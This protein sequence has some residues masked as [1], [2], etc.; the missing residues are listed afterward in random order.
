MR[1]HGLRGR[2]GCR[3]ESGKAKAQLHHYLCQE[4]SCKW[5]SE[6]RRVQLLGRFPVQISQWFASQK[7]SAGPPA[8]HAG[9]WAEVS[10]GEGSPACPEMALALSESQRLP[11]AHV[12][13]H[14]DLEKGPSLPAGYSNHQVI[15][16]FPFLCTQL[17]HCGLESTTFT[18]REIYYMKLMTQ[19]K[20]IKKT[21]K[22]K[23]VYVFGNN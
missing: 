21:E 2:A 3:R 23:K 17:L 11:A 9:T 4:T 15:R 22:I 13:G 7:P 16:K 8:L 19:A 10:W 20:S 12:L 5:P 14:T 6:G 1:T 18:T